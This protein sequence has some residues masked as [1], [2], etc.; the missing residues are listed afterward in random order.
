M[1]W[2]YPRETIEEIG[3]KRGRTEEFG[4]RTAYVERKA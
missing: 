4:I 1:I 3:Q 2:G